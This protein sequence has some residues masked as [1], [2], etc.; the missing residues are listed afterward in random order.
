MGA[1]ISKTTENGKTSVTATGND[2]KYW[3]IEKLP[4][5]KK[6]ADTNKL[7][8]GSTE[9]MDGNKKKKVWHVSATFDTVKDCNNFMTDVKK[10]KEFYLTFEENMKTLLPI[11]AKSEDSNIKETKETKPKLKKVE[12]ETRKVDV[13][14]I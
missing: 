5:V 14:T 2:F 1:E 3:E 9:V 7:L 4:L 10:V 13:V 12:V 11:V 8:T 6:W